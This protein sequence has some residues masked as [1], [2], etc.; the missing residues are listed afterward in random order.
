MKVRQ[1]GLKWRRTKAKT[2]RSVFKLETP[3]NLRLLELW[4]SAMDEDEDGD[5]DDVR[6]FLAAQKIYLMGEIIE[7]NPVP[8]MK[9]K[10][11]IGW[12]AI[13]VSIL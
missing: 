5:F 10:G 7:I 12:F 8:P 1:G 6:T 3:K 4:E 2:W 13:E 11:E 9:A